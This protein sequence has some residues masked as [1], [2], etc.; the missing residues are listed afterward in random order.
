MNDLQIGGYA[1]DPALAFT[2]GKLAAT[3]L[4]III[5]TWVLA[6]AAKWAFAKLVDRIPLLQ[7]QSGGGESIGLALGKIVSLLVWLFG[8]VAVL[9]VLQL[10]DVTAPVQTL[11]D[12]VMAYIPNLV[13]AAIIF[14]V[15]SMIARI[16]RQ[17]VE[18]T[19]RTV[20]FDRWANKGGVEQVTGNATISKTLGTL[21]YVLVIVPVAIAALQALKISS[22]S[23]PL[24]S[25]LQTLLN[26]IPNIIGASILLGL[27]YMIGK[28]VADLAE[29]LLPGLGVDR[30]TKALGLL[31][32]RTSASSIVGKIV[33]VTI[34]LISAVAATKL[35]GFPELTQLVDQIL[36]LGG[37]VIFGGVIIA[38]GFLVA[39]ML[40][41]LVSGAAD[42]IGVLVVRYATIILFAAMGLKYMGIADSIIELA[43]GA[44]VIGGAAAC[45][46]A[47]GLGGRDAAATLLA[48]MGEGK[49][50]NPDGHRG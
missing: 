49:P 40:G 23:D 18:A 42:G 22:I 47:F 6:N 14:F 35:L 17:L 2:F 8:L 30:S 11:L 38:V 27:G 16:I 34:M 39:N 43:F 46:L 20:N 12:N 10:G 21:V 33:M 9:N 25:M 41:K 32:E 26:A 19:L 3:V 15:G 31:P 28:W 4:V 13:G 48:R 37:S 44:L 50:T 29:D 36:K 45:A 24:V 1:F 5:V 7:R